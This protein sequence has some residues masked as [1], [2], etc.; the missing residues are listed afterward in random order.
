MNS[1]F[2][3]ASRMALTFSTNRGD[4]P[5]DSLWSLPLQSKS[6]FDLDTVAKGVARDLKALDEESFV[7][8]Q[9]SPAKERLSLQ[10][11]IL[12]RVIEVKQE[13]NAAK[14]NAAQKAAMRQ[15]LLS[16]LGD[17]QDEE[18]KGMTKEE[19]QKQLDELK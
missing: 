15:R 16:I 8:V 12:K 3:T 1:I 9:T 19:I 4:L 14:A 5:T 2:E 11:E 7:A 6:G 17:K 13:E 10:L 18:L